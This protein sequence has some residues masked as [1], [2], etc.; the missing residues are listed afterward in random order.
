MF[1]IV[2]TEI[3]NDTYFYHFEYGPKFSH[4]PAYGDNIKLKSDL[5]ISDHGDDIPFT[6]GMPFANVTLF[7]QAQFTHHEEE[8]ATDWMRY[9]TNFAMHG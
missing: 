2:Y 1:G 3:G 5:C 4:D 6:F 9:L 8:I 7:K